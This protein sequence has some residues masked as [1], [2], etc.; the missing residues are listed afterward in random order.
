MVA[1]NENGRRIGEGHHNATITDETVN[2]IRELHEDHGIGYRRLARQF[3]L[4]VETVKK[5][6]R[7]QR[8]AATPKAWK[9]V[10]QGRPNTPA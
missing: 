10:E 7:Y 3:G 1:V 2:A 4:H 8:R 5:I 6:C 9:R